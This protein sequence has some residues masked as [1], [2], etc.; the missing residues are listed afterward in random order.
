M[1]RRFGMFCSPYVCEVYILEWLDNDI[2][3]SG[4]VCWWTTQGRCLKLRQETRTIT[5]RFLL[6]FEEAWVQPCTKSCMEQLERKQP[7]I[8]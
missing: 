2:Y 8:L 4:S 3:A 5:K 7:T 1:A 6:V